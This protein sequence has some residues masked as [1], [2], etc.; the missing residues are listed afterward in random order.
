[1]G[2]YKTDLAICV[3][4]SELIKFEDKKT[5]EEIRGYKLRWFIN[6]LDNSGNPIVL[7]TWAPDTIPGI[8]EIEEQEISGWDD[9]LSVG[10]EYGIRE[11][12]LKKKY[13]L[14]KIIFE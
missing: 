9:N 8:D 7:T 11:W 2:I 10:I 6:R 12:E 14:Q 1:M 3:G 5:G 13:T 4:K